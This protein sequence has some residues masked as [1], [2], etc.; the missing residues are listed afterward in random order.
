VVLVS[1]DGHLWELSL[2]RTGFGI[3]DAAYGFDGPLDAHNPTLAEMLE[4]MLGKSFRY[5]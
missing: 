1:T 5:P 2:W 3:P 4:G